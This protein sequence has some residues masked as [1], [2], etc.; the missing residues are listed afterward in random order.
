M[1]VYAYLDEVS[2][3]PLRGTREQSLVYAIEHLVERELPTRRL[4]FDEACSLI[5]DLAIDEDI[6]APT[7]ERIRS[8]KWAGVACHK[9]N[10]IGLQSTSTVLT[11]VHEFAHIV[12]G[13]GHDDLWRSKFVELVRRWVSVDHASLL[14]TLYVR[15]GLSVDD[16]QV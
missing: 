6:D 11:V 1:S 15:T 10:V 9:R 7:V 3:A 13:F 12:A 5:E 16:W 2:C 4:T 8:T 14:H